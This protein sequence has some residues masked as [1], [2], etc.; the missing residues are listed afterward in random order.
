[1]E[2]R[3]ALVIVKVGPWWISN[4]LRTALPGLWDPGILAKCG[5]GGF[6]DLV[7]VTCHENHHGV[8]GCR[9]LGQINCVDENCQVICGDFRGCVVFRKAD[10]DWNGTLQN[11]D[12]DG[13]DSRCRFCDRLLIRYRRE[14]S[15]AMSPYTELIVVYSM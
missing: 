5:L 1:L 10:N 4:T 6:V 13:N 12:E 9:Y 15:V 8:D 2:G 3:F 7:D 11:D 14:Q